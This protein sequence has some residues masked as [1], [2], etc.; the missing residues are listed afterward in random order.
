MRENARRDTVFAWIRVD[1]RPAIRRLRARWLAALAIS[2]TVAVGIAT[3]VTAYGI[4]DAVLFNPLQVR[5]QQ[6]IVVAWA[7]DRTRSESHVGIPAGAVR[8]LA[9]RSTRFAAIGAVHSPGALPFVFADGDR[10]VTLATMPTY[11]LF[12]VLGTRPALGRLLRS[13]DD[14]PGAP[15]AA[16]ISHEAWHREFGGDSAVIGRRLYFGMISPTIVGVA[17]PGFDYPRGTD[18]WLPMAVFNRSVLDNADAGFPSDI[19]A[20]LRPGVTREQAS[21]ELLAMVRESRSPAL[22][23]RA[24]RGVATQSLADA[25]VG[26]VR[27]SVVVVAMATLLVFLIALTNVAGVLVTQGMARTRE[28]AVRAA[29]GATRARLV[30]QLSVENALLCIGGGIAGTALAAALLGI[31]KVS[32]PV[33][34][35]RLADARLDPD[36]LV[37][38]ILGT[39]VAVLAAGVFPALLMSRWNLER[40]LRGTSSGIAS[41]SPNRLFGRAV[42][43]AQVALAVVVL[44]GAGLLTRSF[45]QLNRVE[46]GFEPDRLLFV[47]LQLVIPP[48]ADSALRLRA[49]ARWEPMVDGVRERLSRDPGIAAVTVTS[50]LPFTSAA[51][52]AFGLGGLRYSLDGQTPDQAASNPFAHWDAASSDYF[53][54]LGIRI[55]AGRGFSAGDTRDAE[56]VAV[57]SEGFART[58]W[59]GQ[60]PLGQRV[61]VEDDRGGGVLR[62]V[63]GVVR[64]TRYY[65]VTA[66]PPPSLYMPVSQTRS[67]SGIFLTVRATRG[68][69]ADLLP[70]V[71]RALAD[72]EPWA[73]VRS[74]ATGSQLLSEP[75]SRP[76]ALHGS[77]QVLS[78][79]AVVVAAVGLFGLLGALVRYRSRDIGVRRALGATPAQIRQLILRRAA[80]ITGIGV[81][82]GLALAVV[83]SRLLTE[84]LFDVS[85]TDPLTLAGV[86]LIVLL[87]AW[88]ATYI[89]TR[90][91]V[92]VDPLDILRSTD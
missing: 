1:L 6:D 31:A 86:A 64:D 46:L 75:F 12:P 38:A 76:R 59:P 18:A 87:V 91:A 14:L 84:V 36:V 41:A 17:P 48:T 35:P 52:G 11:N 51:S 90:R 62:T 24:S 20:R 88:A 19:V 7:T 57:V 16:V 63:V 32:F 26:I 61:R 73:A 9:A 68:N 44:T 55:T 83:G 49:A 2:C 79:A 42:V 40:A 67:G 74:V 71:R 30:V 34:I 22:G 92:A 37:V 29:L 78:A 33:G 85:P 50:R 69:P 15:R 77:L 21:T 58:A 81:V 80:S 56:P 27:P 13:E 60:T 3:M 10:K 39:V 89:P 28:L 47:G 4:V 72:V 65:D 5:E 66:A 43:I 82:V 8:A 70:L 25:I 45:A 23:Q 54:T 53:Q